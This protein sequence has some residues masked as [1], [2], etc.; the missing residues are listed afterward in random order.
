MSNPFSG[1]DVREAMDIAYDILMG[2]ANTCPRRPSLPHEREEYGDIIWL[3]VAGQSKFDDEF[4]RL[5]AMWLEAGLP[6]AKFRSPLTE[7]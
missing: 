7:G 5:K 6:E 3:T 4:E 2:F 1:K